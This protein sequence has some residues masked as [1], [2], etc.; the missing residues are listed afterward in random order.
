MS[1]F[2]AKV[3]MRETRSRIIDDVLV[4]G[5]VMMEHSS[6]KT[7]AIAATNDFCGILSQNVTA[8]GPAFEIQNAGIP[9][10]EVKV[11]SAVALFGGEGEIVTSVVA[12]GA[13]PGALDAA[14]VGSSIGIFQ[15]KFRKAQTGD[16]IFGKLREKNYN[17]ITNLFRLEIF[18]TAVEAS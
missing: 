11:G 5:T 6:D 2:E 15:G 4:L 1:I 17:G 8:N 14:V 9:V 7:K 13:E 16:L 10:N 12:L 18:R 3:G